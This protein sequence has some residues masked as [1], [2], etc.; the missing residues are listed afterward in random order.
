MDTAVTYKLPQFEGPLELLLHLISK[1]KVEITDIPVAMI[2]EQYLETLEQMQAMDMEIASSF[3]VMAAQ[4]I[5]IKS[6]TLLP[7]E[8]PEEPEEDPRE[9]LQQAL[10]TYA[11]FK[12]QA[13]LLEADALR[14]L[15][16]ITREPLPLSRLISEGAWEA[17]EYHHRPE[18]LLRALRLMQAREERRSLLGIE[19]ERKF[20]E[21]L[22]SKPVSVE[23]KVQFLMSK[24][25]ESGTLRF[26]DLV[27]GSRSRSDM[28]ALFLA[29]LELL[30]QRRIHT[31]S[32]GTDLEEDELIL[33]AQTIDAPWMTD[34]TQGET[35]N[36]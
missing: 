36:G 18:E 35:Q 31:G 5:Y 27:K 22:G 9:A 23:K 17:P 11:R 32:S 3:I 20:R 10:L 14:G 16:R 6:K 19:S 25:L 8:N 26:G 1:N 7:A 24:L 33:G 13:A 12:E 2:C 29:V 30:G 21:L 28:V 34:N 4:L 15:D